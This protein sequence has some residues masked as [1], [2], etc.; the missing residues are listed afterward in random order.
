MCWRLASFLIYLQYLR[1]YRFSHKTTPRQL[2]PA[3]PRFGGRS[4]T[5][6]PLQST[7]N[8]LTPQ[9]RMALRSIVVLELDAAARTSLEVRWRIGQPIIRANWTGKHLNSHYRLTLSATRLTIIPIAWQA[10][11]GRGRNEVTCMKPSG[12]TAPY[13]SVAGSYL[14]LPPFGLMHSIAVA[15]MAP[16]KNLSARNK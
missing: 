2:L 8:P 12:R 6:R 11:N 9:L 5:A 10:V 15:L 16:N 4:R 7:R 14:A 13:S 1:A 3:I